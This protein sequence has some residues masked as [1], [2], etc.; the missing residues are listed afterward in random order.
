MKNFNLVFF[1][2]I[3][4]FLT[5]S[6]ISLVI[7][8]KTSSIDS[9]VQFL[10]F[11]IVL[12]IFT[13][14]V[15]LPKFQN[16]TQTIIYF[17]EFIPL[18][19]FVYLFVLS[20]GALSSPFLPLT[21]L[22]AIGLAFLI[23]PSVSIVYV[24]ITISTI[25]MN[26]LIDP[27]SKIALYQSPFA[28]F[29]YLF[30]YIAIVPFSYILAKQYKVKEE[31]IN[32]LEKQIATSKTQEENLLRNIGDPVVILTGQMNIAYANQ[33]FFE[34]VGY[35]KGEILEKN[36]FS[37]FKIKDSNG[38]DLQKEE[39]PFYSVL[40]TKNEI[41]IDKVQINHKNGSYFRA[42]I[43][44]S[45]LIDDKGAVLGLL[46]VIKE[47]SKR[48]L[49]IA[50]NYKQ[51]SQKLFKLAPE[52]IRNVADDLLLLSQLESSQSVGISEFIDVAPV[53]ENE[54]FKQNSYAQKRNIKITSASSKEEIVMPKKGKVFSPEKKGMF[55]SVY[56]LADQQLMQRAVANLLKIALTLSPPSKVLKT[57][58]Y[59]EDQVVRLEIFIDTQIAQDRLDLLF[60]KFFNQYL[61]SEVLDKFTGLEIAVAKNI[62]EKHGGDLKMTRTEKGTLFSSTMIRLEPPQIKS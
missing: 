4:V 47:S 39:L 33:S 24:V 61:K 46:L 37:K 55:P 20:T 42:N 49:S 2:S 27:T 44:T 25:A 26:L 43:K 17:I 59:P 57:N 60:Q 14:R 22:L 8:N 11:S 32:I 28:A 13:T 6:L 3:F 31:W 45:P 35:T 7:I 51:I 52:Q 21:H 15:I 38:K 56:I 16:F 9:L 58:L 23:S 12:I 62:F 10:A 50:T 48:D 36:F 29:L 34:K 19:L 5:N 54:V 30:A 18:S 53:I 40:S 41:Q 1:G